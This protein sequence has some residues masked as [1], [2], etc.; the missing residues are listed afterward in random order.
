M[1]HSPLFLNSACSDD[2]VKQIDKVKTKS[3]KQE[4]DRVKTK[5]TKQKNKKQIN[6]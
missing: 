4:N 2:K 6:K 1:H 3:T 5:S